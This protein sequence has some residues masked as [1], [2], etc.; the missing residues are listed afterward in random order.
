MFN[1]IQHAVPRG[2]EMDAV[3]ITD[4]YATE[5]GWATVEAWDTPDGRLYYALDESDELL[6][7]ATPRKV[8]AILAARR[9]VDWHGGVCDIDHLPEG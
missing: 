8:S 4:A 7:P 2:F 1:T 3:R 6:A 5:H 9:Y